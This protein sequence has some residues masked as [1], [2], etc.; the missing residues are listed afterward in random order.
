MTGIG[1]GASIRLRP[2]IRLSIDQKIQIQ[3]RLLALRLELI[4]ALREDRYSPQGV[5]PKCGRNLTPAEIISGF[6]RDPFDYTTRCTSCGV[7]FNPKIISK[8]IETG[9][10]VELPFF[11]DV[12]TL[13]ELRDWQDCSPE[14]I[15]SRAKAIYHS[16]IIHFGSISRAMKEAGIIYHYKEK[17]DWKEKVVPFLGEMPDSVIARFANVSILTVRKFRN[18]KGIEKFDIRKSL[19]M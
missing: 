9:I 17:L 7:R 4:E 1:V 14:D 13:E 5:C 3:S 6:N 8:R 2:E 19:E 15:R 11:C 16:A 18:R 10:A 12:Q